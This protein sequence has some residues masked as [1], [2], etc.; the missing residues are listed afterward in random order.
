[1]KIKF[2]PY[3]PHCFAFGG[4][5][6]QMINAMR[7]MQ[8]LGCD[9]SQLDIWSRD[10]DFDVLHLWGIGPHNYHVIDWAKKSEKCLVATVLL[11]YFD[12]FRSK[13]GNLYREIFSPS[14][15][16]LVRY[17]ALIDRIVVVNDLQADVLLRYFKVHEN[18]I[19]VIPNIV[20]D[21]FF[22][23]SINSFEDKYQIRD[24]VLCTG[25]ISSRKNQLNLAL[26]CI[27]R[28]FPLVLIGNELT[29]E[30]DYASK[31]SEIVS[32]HSNILWLDEMQSASNELVAAYNACSFFALPSLDETQPISALEAVA[33]KKPIM[34]LDRQYAK[35]EYYK[36]AV[37]CKSTSV[38]DISTALDV[39]VSSNLV[40]DSQY[41]VAC[42]AINV[43][44]AYKDVYLK[45]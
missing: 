20:D 41:I 12:T 25:N 15:M 4:F 5:D 23:N 22:N 36:G 13:I 40:F 44:K 28:G 24:F 3:Q 45:L 1:M 11:P 10:S 32:R 19:D 9:V 7:S 14:F 38:S 35:Q 43:G 17:F 30:S 42:R 27:S 8:N 33:V 37:L 31:L 18:K 16:Q 26:A 29:G 2:Y 21:N 6:L 34:L 39:L